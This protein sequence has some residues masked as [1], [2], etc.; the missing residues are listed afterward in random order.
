MSYD[1][2]SRFYDSLT[3]NVEYEKRAPQG[4]GDIARPRLRHGRHLYRGGE[5]GI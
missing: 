4:E 3:D 5:K 2:F 1:V